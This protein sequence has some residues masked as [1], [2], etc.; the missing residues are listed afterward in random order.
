[1]AAIVLVLAAV[2]V[3]VVVRA[4]HADNDRLLTATLAQTDDVRIRRPE[5]GWSSMVRKGVAAR[6][7]CRPGCRTRRLNE[8]RR[9]MGGVSTTCTWA[10]PSTGSSPST[11]ARP[12]GRPPSI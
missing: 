12:C 4:Q 8:R 5:C 10:P 2:A 1:V 7:V 9:W 6:P 3:L 11:T